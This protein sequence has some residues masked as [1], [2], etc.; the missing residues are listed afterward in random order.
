MRIMC[1]IL[2]LMMFLENSIGIDDLPRGIRSK[3]YPEYVGVDSRLKTIN[4]EF[5]KLAKKSGIVFHNKVT[6]GFKN[7]NINHIVGLTHYGTS[8]RE[9]DIDL[10]AWNRYTWLMKVEL[11]YHELVHAYCTRS[12]DYGEGFPYNKEWLDRITILDNSR[13]GYLNDG[14]PK[15]VMF[16]YVMQEK[17]FKDHYGYYVKEMFNRCEA[18]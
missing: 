14:C 6:I 1:I 16:P 4:S 12:H 5:L 9:I 18:Y 8:F 3:P 2:I 10:S 13:S 11:V 15:S 7:I 17:C